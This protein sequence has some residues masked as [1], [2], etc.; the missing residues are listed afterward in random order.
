LGHKR[1]PNWIL[2]GRGKAPQRDLVLLEAEVTTV[3]KPGN[4]SRK[5][6]REKFSGRGSTHRHTRSST[7]ADRSHKCLGG[8]GPCGGGGGGGGVG[9]GGGGFGF[10]GGGG[11]VWLG[12]G[13][14]GV[15]VGFSLVDFGGVWGGGGCG[16]GFFLVFCVGFVVRWGE[17]GVGGWGLLGGGGGVFGVPNR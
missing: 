4:G 3:R 13:G 15:C 16:L 14:G 7:V 10:R 2:G 1:E 12:V 5:D 9:G 6:L 11:F 8:K 17:G